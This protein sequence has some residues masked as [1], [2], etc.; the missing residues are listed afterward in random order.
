MGTQTGKLFIVGHSGTLAFG[1]GSAVDCDVISFEA[2]HEFDQLSLKNG[3]GST[4]GKFGYNERITGR[5]TIRPSASS[6]PKMF[7][8]PEPLSTV[9]LSGFEPDE[10]GDVEGRNYINGTYI[11]RGNWAPRYVSGEP[12][13]VSF[14]VYQGGSALPGQ[15]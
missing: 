9:A 7:A 3:V 14:D 2:T 13:E 12:V 15:P 11:Y 6:S 4:V 1:G 5:I 8:T 10:T